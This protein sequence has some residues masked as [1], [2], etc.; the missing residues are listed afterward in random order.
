MTISR[1]R[2]QGNASISIQGC[3][4][5]RL[6]AG[7]AQVG[8]PILVEIGTDTKRNGHTGGWRHRGFPENPTAA[9]GGSGNLSGSV[10]DFV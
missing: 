5:E 8:N 4:N 3:T 6:A 10:D 1:G 2:W 7:R 9:M